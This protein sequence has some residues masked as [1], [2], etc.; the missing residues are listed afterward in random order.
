[1]PYIKEEC[2]RTIKENANIVDVVG[3]FVELKKR[4]ANYVGLSPFSNEKTPSF[5]VSPVRNFYKCFSTGASGDAVA[6]LMDTQK[7]TYPEALE[8]LASK[9]NMQV[10]Y[11]DSEKAIERAAREQQRKDLRPILGEAIR[12]YQDAFWQ[13]PDDHAAKIEVFQKRQYTIEQAKDWGIGYAEGG[14]FLFEKLKERKLLQEGREIGLIGEKADKY[15][16]RVIYPIYDRNNLPVGMGGRDISGQKNAAKWINSSESLIYK[17][18]KI[19]YGLHK[20][21]KQIA[22]TGEAWIV[23]GYNDVMSLHVNGLESAIAPCG[24]A[25]TERQMNEL[26]R[27]C[28]KVVFAMDPDAAGKKSVLKAIP[29]FLKAGFMVN[30]YEFPQKLDPDD[31]CRSELAKDMAAKSFCKLVQ[32]HADRLKPYQADEDYHV[33][34]NPFPLY[35]LWPDLKADFKNGFFYLMHHELS[36]DMKEK[37]EGIHKLV[38]IISKLDDPINES[39]YMGGLQKECKLEKSVLNNMLKKKQQEAVEKA[40]EPTEY[41]MPPGLDDVFEDVKPT[42]EKYAMFMAKKQIWM[43]RGE[44]K[45]YYFHS[46]ANFDIEFLQHMRD[47]KFPAKLVRITNVNNE[48][49]VFDVPSNELNTPQQFDNVMSQHGNFLWNGGRPEFQRL[50]KYLYDKMGVGTKVEVLGWQPDGFWI[51]NNGAIV[52]GKGKVDITEFG[53]LTIEKHCYYVPSANKIYRNNPYKFAPQKL[54]RIEQASCTFS[55]FTRQFVKV[56]REHAYCALL[57]TM[58]S[59]FLDIINEQEGFFPLLFLYGPPSTGKDKMIEICQSFF[60]QPQ[61]RIHLGN[62]TSTQKAQ[63]RKF[64]QFTNMIVHLSEYNSGNRQ[65]NEMLKGIWDRAGYERGNIES[66][67]GTDTVPILS[68]VMFTGNH[69]LD[70]DALITRVITEEV[71]K[72]EFTAEDVE[73][74]QKLEE[75]M[76]TGISSFTVDILHFREEFKKEF[77]K[78]FKNAKAKL[79]EA[80]SLIVHEERMF[81]NAAVY[82]ATLLIMKDRMNIPFTFDEFTEH[83]KQVYT[84]QVRKLNIGSMI[85]KFWNLFLSAVRMQNDPLVHEREFKIQGDELRINITHVYNRVAQLWFSQYQEKAPGISDVMDAIKRDDTVFIEQKNSIRYGDK[86]SSG[87][88][89]RLDRLSIKEDLL[90]TINWKENEHKK[91]FGNGSSTEVDTD[92]PF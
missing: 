55:D 29:M 41:T 28:N 50:R 53:V 45:P 72:T 66:N 8:W 3:H 63:I 65:T 92:L 77:P 48:S 5:T 57:H 62:N 42:I 51:F 27:Y 47:E 82:G 10:E 44:D 46:V 43:M 26:S 32:K 59:V 64:A 56:H 70:D 23:E 39:I 88:I 14:H 75:M 67:V 31:F 86:K 1:M 25:I 84:R 4:G 7:M 13:L 37:A 74:F 33:K 61:T 40:N 11:D 19:W 6:F 18:D 9:F 90:E 24:T 15:W 69:Y 20:A 78:A 2:A 35:C 58:A 73:E 76:K 89:L 38:D 34:A 68:S 85:E 49:H 30:I 79:K 60:G 17:K 87:W 16:N 80:L 71:M 36:G 91:K 12:K 22:K 52:P 21:G 81:S 83:M 54:V